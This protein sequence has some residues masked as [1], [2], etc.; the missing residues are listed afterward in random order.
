M[1]D[2]V[3][4]ME[5][6]AN[7]LGW[8]I[9]LSI[10]VGIGWLVFLILW[11]FFYAQNYPWEKNFSIFLLSLLLLIGVLGAPWAYWAYRKQTSDEKELWRQKGFRWRFWAS[12]LVGLAVLLFLIYWFWV[13]AAPYDIYRNLAIFIVTLLIG[14]GLVAAMWVPWSMK[15]DS[16]THHHEDDDK[17]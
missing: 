17:E 15:Y 14:G 6:E 4:P 8:R 16:L 12:L 10:L 2:G 9:S 5:K 13:Y 3:H 7:G 11:L 1:D